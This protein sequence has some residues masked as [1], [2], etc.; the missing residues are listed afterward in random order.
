MRARKT[1]VKNAIRVASF[2]L[3][4]MEGW[5]VRTRK[6]IRQ[7]YQGTARHEKRYRC[8]YRGRGTAQ[9]SRTG[10]S[11]KVYKVKRASATELIKRCLKISYTTA[12]TSKQNQH[13][14]HKNKIVCREQTS[15]T[16]PWS[17]LQE[18]SEWSRNS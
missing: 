4:Y 11:S 9:I 16:C 2:Q 7:L 5:L 10:R 6:H 15:I 13:I 18:T 17:T 8:W 14:S 1:E 12:L 3:T